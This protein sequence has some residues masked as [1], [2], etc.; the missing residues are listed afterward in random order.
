MFSEQLY[1]V[2][3][4]S[5]LQT[6]PNDFITPESG[7]TNP[8]HTSSGQRWQRIIRSHD[9]KAL[10][11]AIDWKGGLGENSRECPSADDFKI[12]LEN[13]TNSDNEFVLDPND[14]VTNTSVPILD[15]P[16]QPQEI[17]YVLRKQINVNKGSGIDV[18]IFASTLSVNADSYSEECNGD[19]VPSV[20]GV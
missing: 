9:D 11:K 6:L 8:T 15:N 3:S 4:D 17:D 14:Y 16:I 7:A 13:I 19:W 20:L 1:V 5:F 12:H 10:W 2:A 18:Q